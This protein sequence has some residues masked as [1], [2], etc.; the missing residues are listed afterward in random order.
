M[1]VE[2]TYSHSRADD[3]DG[4]L[5][6][7]GESALLGRMQGFAPGRVS[8]ARTSKRPSAPSMWRA[9]RNWRAIRERLRRFFRIHGVFEN[10]LKI[11]R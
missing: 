2:L 9:R 5:A 1:G 8:I 4:S 3:D 10:S 6:L 11:R 7:S